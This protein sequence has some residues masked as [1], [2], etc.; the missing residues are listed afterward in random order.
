MQ[1]KNSFYRDFLKRS[2]VFVKG[3]G[4]VFDLDF[5]SKKQMSPNTEVYFLE[6]DGVCL[7]ITV[8]VHKKDSASTNNA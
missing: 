1:N 4:L 2:E 6:R 7:T 8:K 5:R 3:I